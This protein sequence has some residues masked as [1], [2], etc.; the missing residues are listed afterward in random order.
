[1]GKRKKVKS[2]D[3]SVILT[4]IETGSKA[5]SWRV[6]GT[7]DGKWKIFGIYTTEAKARKRAQKIVQAEDLRRTRLES[8]TDS[9]L[10]QVI[11][12]LD[13]GLS[14]DDLG[15]LAKRKATTNAATLGEV[16]QEWF[17]TQTALN[18]YSAYYT[19]DLKYILTN[20]PAYLG[21]GKN[22]ASITASHLTGWLGS[23]T[24]VD[25]GAISKKRYK[26]LRGVLV[27]VWAWA[28][29]DLYGYAAENVA[30]K[31]AIPRILS[32]SGGHE[33]LT[34]QEFSLMLGAVNERCLPWLAVSGFAGLRQSEICGTAGRLADRL[35]WED[36]DWKNA[37]I[38][39]RAESSK[40]RLPRF[41]PICPAL[42]EWLEPWKNA[43]GFVHVGHRPSYAKD[44]TQISETKRLGALVGGWRANALR[45]SRASYR[46]AQT[47]DIA[48]T[49]LEDGHTEAMLRK[50]YLN[51]R[52]SEDAALWFGLTPATVDNLNSERVVDI[53]HKA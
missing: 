22:F 8:L 53:R 41:V 10:D 26:N 28:S 19:N 3:R 49:A 23:L 36:F 20:L 40:T 31:V 42:A 51:P 16:L 52:F 34:P 6:Q 38:I 30:S 43:R 48:L 35:R 33:V 5:G 12:F 11:A 18:E 29:L 13:S 2:G 21:P 46:I 50:N 45:A 25:G 44:K 9:Q 15:D 14:M 39:V 24:R 47:N 37:R 32:R 1:M 7:Q 27:S 4:Q 17:D